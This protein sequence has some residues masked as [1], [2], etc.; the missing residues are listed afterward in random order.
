MIFP[1]TVSERRQKRLEE[2]MEIIEDG[3]E[4]TI[5]PEDLPTREQV[6][7]MTRAR[8]RLRQAWRTDNH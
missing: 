4:P 1:C 8:R 2:V 3:P 5:T 7:R 6:E